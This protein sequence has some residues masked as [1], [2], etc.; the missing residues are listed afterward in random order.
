MAPLSKAVL[1]SPCVD[2]TNG[3]YRDSVSCSKP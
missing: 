2:E 1:L 3:A